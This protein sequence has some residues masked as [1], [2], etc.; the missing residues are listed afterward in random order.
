MSSEQSGV[1]HCT[2]YRY[3]LMVES[4]SYGQD[5]NVEQSEHYCCALVVAAE[6]RRS[7]RAAF[8]CQ[9]RGLDSQLPSLER[10]RFFSALLQPADVGNQGLE[11]SLGIQ[12]AIDDIRHTCLLL[13][14]PLAQQAR[15]ENEVG[16]C[17]S[18]PADAAPAVHEHS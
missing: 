18:V 1:V 6:H 2:E 16:P 15:S 5:C 11:W 3:V 14:S 10:C 17:D 9:R 4:T 8:V 7:H 13:G 12:V